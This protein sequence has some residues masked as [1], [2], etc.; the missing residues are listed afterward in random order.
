MKGQNFESLLF[1]GG[2]YAKGGIYAEMSIFRYGLLSFF[3]SVD[4]KKGHKLGGSAH[5][6]V[7]RK[8]TVFDFFRVFG[9]FPMLFGVRN[10]V[11]IFIFS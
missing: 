9:A 7:P 6:T 3:R 8:K 1:L 5:S 11:M 10:N 4:K 2:I